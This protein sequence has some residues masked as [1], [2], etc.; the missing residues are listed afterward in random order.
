MEQLI[1]KDVAQT[2]KNKELFSNANLIL[3][4]G[5]I[6]GLIG[7]NGSGK[8]IL[9][10]TILG[11][12]PCSKGMIMF[13]NSVLGKDMEFP[14]NAGFLIDNPS[15]ILDYNQYANLKLLSG[16]NNKIKKDN[17][18]KSLEMVGLDPNNR[19]KVKEFS[20]GMK[21]RL[22]IAQAIMENPDLLILD[23]PMNGLDQMGIDLVRRLILEFKKDDRIIIITSH[24]KQDIDYLCDDVIEI[25]DKKVDFV[26]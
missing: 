3:T 22:G 16:I 24:N 14:N 26:N 7:E 11:L 18:F 17:I 10:K 5:K 13:D 12:V 15:F 4:S 21:Q 2:L 23:E 25:K 19:S 6:Y 8:T 1:I 9:L 20:L